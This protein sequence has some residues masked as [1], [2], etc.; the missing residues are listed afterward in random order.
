ME[1]N[2]LH[3]AT[4]TIKCKSACQRGVTAEDILAHVMNTLQVLSPQI[5]SPFGLRAEIEAAQRIRQSHPLYASMC[6]QLLT[7]ITNSRLFTTV[8]QF[9]LCVTYVLRRAPMTRN[10]G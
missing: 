9:I 3:Q 1:Q 6:L 7:E 5:P 2:P 8:R 4:S 10:L